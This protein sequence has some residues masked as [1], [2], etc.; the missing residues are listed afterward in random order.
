MQQ[1]LLAEASEVQ[2]HN[3]AVADVQDVVREAVDYLQCMAQAADVHLTSTDKTGATLWS[4]DRGALF[5]L[6][7]NLLENAIQHAPRGTRM[8]VEVDATTLTVRDRGTGV[9]Q[10]QLSKMFVRFWRGAHRREYSAG[11]GLA[12]CQKSLKYP[13]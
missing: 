3:F 8:S 9:E 2:N 6:L 10:E 7:E 1:L 13:N 4:A 12:I 5:I 11:L